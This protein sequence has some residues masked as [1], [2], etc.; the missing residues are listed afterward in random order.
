[1][2]R[3]IT[4]TVAA[5]IGV[6]TMLSGCSGAG[7]PVASPTAASVYD[8]AKPNKG[9]APIKVSIAAQPIVSNGALYAGVDEGFFAENGLE[10]E[11]QPVA[12]IAASIA[13]VQGG[14]S[15][16]GFATTVSILQAVD[17][18]VPISMIAPF[19]GIAPKYYEKMEA[20]EDGYTTEITAIVARGG[21]RISR[22]QDLE[23]KTVAVADARGQAELTTRFV[24]DEDGGDSDKVNYTVMAFPDALNAFKA[25]Q[26]DA[27]F[28]VEPFLT[29]AIEAGGVII[30]WP[31]V[32]T[33]RE[34]PTSA[35]ISSDSYIKANEETVARMNCA[36]R[37]SNEFANENP[38]VIRAAVAKAQNVEPEK[39]A[40]AVVPYYYTTVDVAGLER[41]AGIMLD[42]GFIS[43]KIDPNDIVTSGALAK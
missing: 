20:G 28:S 36:I 4:F 19:A 23:G 2:K 34:G 8:C 22:P 10:L 5:A 14:T 15:N 41:F 3:Q 12:N 40:K 27:M 33:F 37:S 38:D 6:A 32:E 1:M 7:T 21:T 17:S 42:Y 25:G 24:V 35:I 43:E 9:D 16:F 30:S 26:V 31:G 13:S 11:I 18:G 39:L 29:Q